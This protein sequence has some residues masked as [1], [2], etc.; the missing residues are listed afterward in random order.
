VA[1]RRPPNVARRLAV[2]LIVM[3]VGLVVIAG[4]LVTLQGSDRAHYAQLSRHQLLRTTKLE[5]TR[6]SIVD[7]NGADLALS[8]PRPTVFV[9]PSAVVEPHRTAVRLAAILGQRVATL[10]TTLTRTDTRYVVIRKEA[11]PK[12]EAAIRALDNPG[13]ALQPG[14][15]RVM[16]NGPLAGPV[17]GF[18]NGKGSGGGG[19][20]YGYQ[21]TL[22]GRAGRLDAE[23]DPSG[24]EIPATERKLTPAVAGSDLV[25]TLDRGLQYQV[26][27]QLTSEVSATQAKGGMALIADV[28]SGDILAAAV[29]DG[30]TATVPA[31]PA[32]ASES[33]RLFTT[34][35]EPGSTNKVITIASALENHTITP[36]Q[37]FDVPARIKIGG[38]EFDD[39]E[40]HREASWSVRQIL[41]ASSNVGTIRIAATLGQSRLERSL[42]EFGLGTPTPV[43]FP[44]ESYGTLQAPDQG[45]P[46]IMG[47]LPIGYGVNATA[48]QT[49]GV[50]M[51]IANGGMTR[52][53]RLVDGTID[54]DGVRHR[55][56]TMP[57]RRIISTST[58]TILNDLMRDV[59]TKGTGEAAAIPGYTVAGKTG[60]ARKQP[61]AEHKY[62]ASF[63]G[64]APA[65]S[66]RFAA[67]VVL[68][69]P[70]TQIYGGAVAAPVFSKIM[71]AALRQEHV[72]PTRAIEPDA[73]NDPAQEAT[74]KVSSSVP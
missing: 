53:L 38:A 42:R 9:D 44:G 27:Q 47:S 14:W 66:P 58:A 23:R 43:A 20:E 36:D 37:H 48:A 71:Q 73:S 8:V 29:I 40:W 64:F 7:R 25:L 60:T 30:A 6:G 24:R 22:A 4:K 69:E 18:V 19:V 10:D 11:T 31:H 2:M 12:V 34:P 55:A 49:L 45:D 52:P 70:K 56:G 32:A 72:P 5:P 50:Y 26:E 28:H 63:A 17:I 13:V 39:D 57:R 74:G 1:V 33:N 54:A 51:T 61:Y 62:M 41:P 21:K 15:Q 67:V 3:L 65:E 59:V 16:P 35:Y 68:D 46:T